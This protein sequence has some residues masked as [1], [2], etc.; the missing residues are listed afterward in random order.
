MMIDIVNFANTSKNKPAKIIIIN[1]LESML[2]LSL[3]EN[4]IYLKKKRRRQNQ[5]EFSFDTDDLVDRR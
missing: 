1:I 2:K 5:I 3:I 4:I